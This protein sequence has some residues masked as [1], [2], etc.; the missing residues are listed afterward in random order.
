MRTL[1]R[2]AVSLTLTCLAFAQTNPAPAE[3]DV[4][5]IKQNKSGELQASANALPSGQ[6][7]VKNMPLAQLI[8]FA[9]DVSANYISGKPDWVNSERFDMVG[10]F[11]PGAS[12]AT[13]REMLQTMLAREFKLLVHKEEKPMNVFAMIVGKDGPKLQAAVDEKGQPDCKRV[14]GPV[15]DGQQHIA[16]TG[17]KASDLARFL[18]QI[19]SGYI[20]RPVVDQ[21][22]LTGVYDLKLDWVGV[23]FIAQGGLTMPD[24][25]AKQL[26]LKL[27]ERKLPMT[28]IVIDRIERLVSTN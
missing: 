19:A 24:A 15:I 23:N 22:G 9:Y 14:G 3:F 8:Q 13:T 21:T 26:G 18:P 27:E 6:F 10:K 4:V 11:A 2:L 7:A 28:T 20:D 25:V 5:D 12:D 1:A 17:L 16:C